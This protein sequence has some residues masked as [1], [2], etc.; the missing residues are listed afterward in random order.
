MEKHGRGSRGNPDSRGR[1]PS[2]RVET[3][4]RLSAAVRGRDTEPLRAGPQTRPAACGPREATS[5][6]KVPRGCAWPLGVAVRGAQ[7]QGPGTSRGASATGGGTAG[8]GR[9]AA[10]P[11]LTWRTGVFWAG[12]GGRASRAEG[13]QEHRGVRHAA[14]PDAGVPAAGSRGREGLG[15][16]RAG[17][18]QAQQEQRGPAEEGRGAGVSVRFR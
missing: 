3:R 15:P 7:W 18:P 13:R 17:A 6:A 12:N 8:N 5:T 2:A 10:R 16:G 1:R 14:Q 9:E 11:Q 4:H